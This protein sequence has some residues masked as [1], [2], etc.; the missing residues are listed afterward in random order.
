VDYDYFIGEEAIQALGRIGSDSIP[1]LKQALAQSESPHKRWRAAKALS[2][3]GDPDV[4]ESLIAALKDDEQQVRYHV[5]RALGELG[6]Q[7]AIPFLKDALQ[8][9]HHG[10]RKEALRALKRLG[11]PES[12]LPEVADKPKRKRESED[13]SLERFQEERRLPAKDSLRRAMLEKFVAENFEVGKVYQEKEV[14][15]IISRAYDDYCSVRR[16]F[17]DYGMMSRD[18]G[19]YWVNT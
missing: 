14:N 15:E 18:R 2:E 7:D 6:N 5:A 3:I 16:Y 9:E 8:D 17:V 4:L 1:I 13:S 10:V 19:R 11:V 12:E